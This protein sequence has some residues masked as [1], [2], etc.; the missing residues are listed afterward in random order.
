MYY[1]ILPSEMLDVVL[2]EAVKKYANY[3]KDYTLREVAFICSELKDG[4][5]LVSCKLSNYQYIKNHC[6]L[7]EMSEMEITMAKQFYG[8]E[9]LLIEEQ[10]LG[11]QYK[12]LEEII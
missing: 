2:P 3:D 6:V 10:I 1:V 9:N 12:N 4:N 11:L 7:E 5:W 8:E